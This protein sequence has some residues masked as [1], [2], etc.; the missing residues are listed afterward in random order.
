[1][2]HGAGHVGQMGQYRVIGRPGLYGVCVADGGGHEVQLADKQVE[3]APVLLGE[4]RGDE[5]GGGAGEVREAA[6]VCPALSR[7]MVVGRD[8]GLFRGGS[9]G[10]SRDGAAGGCAAD[11]VFAP[12]DEPVSDVD[13]GVAV[14]VCGV[15][16]EYI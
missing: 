6:G 10:G 5:P 3:G 2:S 16:F 13:V 12:A 4:V 1:M 7:E 11:A 9:E 14:W 15:L 8:G